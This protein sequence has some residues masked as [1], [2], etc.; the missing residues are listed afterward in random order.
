MEPLL[1]DVYRHA[2]RAR[3]AA[4]RLDVLARAG[5]I[6][7]HPSAQRAEVAIVAATLALE[8][9]DFVAPTPR[10]FPAML[11]RGI[12]VAAY[13]AHAVGSTRDRQLGHS[14]PGLFSSREHGVLPPSQLVAQH[15]TQ[16]TGFA[17]AMRMK[18]A[19]GAV[20][21]FL[22]EAAADAGDFHSAVNF[23]GVTKAPIVFLVREGEG[24]PAP[25]VE[26][27]DKAVAY[28]VTSARSGG[29]PGEVAAAVSRAM[30]R[31]RAGEGPTLLQVHVAAATDPLAD[32]RVLLLK[33]GTLTETDDFAM[34]RAMMGELETETTAALAAGPPDSSALFAEVFA[35]P[36]P[37]LVD[38][39]ACL[40][41]ARAA[42]GGAQGTVDA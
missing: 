8:A 7:F 31:A 26:V 41:R 15:L 3:A 21:A 33:E 2:A 14:A 13:V 22:S 30:A 37:Y 27:A 29:A 34:R 11:A 32:L 36:P 16:A 40:E 25:D 24:A 23:A 38:Q 28:G 17:W 6:G 5:R 1:L 10:D 35:T 4:E 19:P 39:E 9:H 20:L 42:K 12:P 18:K